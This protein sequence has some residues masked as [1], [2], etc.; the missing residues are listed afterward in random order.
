LALGH[1]WPWP[2]GLGPWPWDIC[3]LGLEGWGLGL[4]ILA[5]TTSL[6]SGVCIKS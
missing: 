1:V 4:K 2:R 3:G 5:F 6:K